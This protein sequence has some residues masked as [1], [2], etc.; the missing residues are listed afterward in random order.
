[1]PMTTTLATHLRLDTKIEAHPSVSRQLIV[2]HISEANGLGS[3][4]YL[5]VPLSRVDEICA[6]L[7][8]AHAEAH[9]TAPA[10]G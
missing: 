1:M 4:T 9:N 5:Y 7:V 2:L 6:A 8:A 3:D 10:I